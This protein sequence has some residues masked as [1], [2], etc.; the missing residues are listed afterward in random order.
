MIL[1]FSTTD[2]LQVVTDAAA[3]VHAHVSWMDATLSGGTIQN[4]TMQPGRSNTIITTATTTDVAASPGT[5]KVRNVKTVHIR[6]ADATLSVGVVVQHTDGTNTVQLHGDILA[7]GEAMEYIEGIG[8]FRIKRDQ[9]KLLNASTANQ[10]IGASTTAYLSGSALTI[11]QALLKAGTVLRWTVV[12]S[13]TAASTAQESIAIR[14]GTTATTSDAAQNTFTGDTETAAADD[15]VDYI[16]AIVRGPIGASCIV[17]AL[18]MRDDNLS[19]TGFSNTARKAQVRLSTSSAFDITTA[20]YVGV[21]IT[22][23]TSHSLTVRQV[24]AE[25]LLP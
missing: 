12:L 16:Q 6:N 25:M 1:L 4:N 11:P 21:S 7:P 9:A 19:T 5:N 22:T 14:F 24:V 20:A 15:A 2:K 18:W 13:K 17:E 10:S 8:F 3:T 23:G